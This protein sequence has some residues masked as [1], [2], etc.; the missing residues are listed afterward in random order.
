MMRSKGMIVV[1][2][3][4]VM[5]MLKAQEK[6][7]ISIDPILPI[8]GTF[9]FQYE[10]A[11]SDKISV[12]VSFGVKTTSGV[13]R[14]SGID[15]NRISTDDFNFK[16]VKILPEFR[17]YIQNT[18]KKLSGFYVGVYTK[19]QNFTDEILGV[20]TDN[21]GIDNA[22]EIDAKII[23]LSGG[24]EIGY[25]FM[26]RKRFFIDFLIAG[27]GISANKI[28][29]IEKQPIPESFYDD[30]SEVLSEYE[31]FDNLN[32]DFRINGNQDTDII[33]PAFRWGIKL[34]YSF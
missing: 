33:L 19:Y 3:L 12:G 14:I 24:V 30:V 27:P 23:T 13:F 34:G 20:Y 21:N 1:C 31:L 28:K 5:S 9:Q 18:T 2:F 26:I 8:F 10:R 32:L 11:I 16:G 6:N 4:L 29:L 17:W 15:I 25:K 7:H 22:I